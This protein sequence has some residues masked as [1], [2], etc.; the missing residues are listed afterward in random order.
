MNY[1]I[2]A[3]EAMHDWITKYGKTPVP[4]DYIENYHKEN[5]SSSWDAD[6]VDHIRILDYTDKDIQ[7][8]VDFMD[9][10]VNRFH[11]EDCESLEELSDQIGS[12]LF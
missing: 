12:D 1:N 9:K 2:L 7:E 3:I 5:D 8:E 10:S 11:S 6:E 4:V